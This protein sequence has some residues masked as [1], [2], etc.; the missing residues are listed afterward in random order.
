V[1]PF[2]SETPSLPPPKEKGDI[3]RDRRREKEKGKRK[4][5]K[6]REIGGTK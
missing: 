6:D 2:P 5:K 1:T 4:E 3:F